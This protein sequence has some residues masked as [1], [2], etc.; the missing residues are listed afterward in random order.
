V[1]HND[2]TGRGEVTFLGAYF[3]HPVTVQN[4]A[5]QRAIILLHEAVHQAGKKGDA[6]FNGVSA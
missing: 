4:L 1:F 2:V 6:V 5:E 3:F